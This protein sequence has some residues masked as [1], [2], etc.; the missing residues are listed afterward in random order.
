M[1]DVT[2]ALDLVSKYQDP[3]SPKMK[4][5]DWRPLRDVQEELGGIPSIPGHVEDFGAFM[6]E[7]ARKAAGPGLSPRDLIKAYAITRSS[8]QRRAQDAERLR[9]AGLDLPAG[10]SGQIRPEGAMAEWLKSPTGQ[11]Y[12]DAAEVGKVDQDAVAHAQSVMKPFGLNAESQALPWA[13]QNLSDKHGDVSSMVKRAISGDSPVAEWRE[14]GKKL[15]GIGTAKAGFVASMLGRGDQPTLDARQVILQ[16]GMPTSEAKKPMAKAGF[17]AV[18]RLAARQTALNPSMDPGL[19]PF[20]QHLT[21]HTIWDKAGNEQTT[22]SDVI[23]AMRHANAGGRVGKAGGGAKSQN[24]IIAHAIA[25]LGV[26]GHGLDQLVE[27]SLVELMRSGSTQDFMRRALEVAEKGGSY[28][29]TGAGLMQKNQELVNN[30]PR[31]S[32]IKNT[33]KSGHLITPLSEMEAEYAPKKNLEPWK[34][35]D[36]EKANRE[37][38]TLVPLVGDNTPANAVLRSVMGVPAGDVNQQGGGDYIRSEFARGDNPTGWRNRTGAANTAM[39]R[40][41]E[42]GKEGPVVGLHMAMGL[43]SADSS[44]MLLHSVVNQINHLPIKKSDIDKFD[45]EMKEKFPDTKEF[46]MPWPGIKDTQG[47]HDFFYNTGNPKRPY[48]P[49]THVSKFVQNMDSVRWRAA[50]FPDVGAARFANADPRLLGMPQLSSG[51]SATELDPAGKL[52]MNK[53]DM[54]HGTYEAGLPHKGYAG[55]FRAPVQAEDIWTTARSEMPEKIGGKP[56]DYQTPGGKTL[57]QQKLMTAM[58]G[59]KMNNQIADT[60]QKAAESGATFGNYKTG[61]AVQPT[62]AQKE[63]GNYRKEHISFQGLPISIETRKGQT[64]SGTGPNGHKWSVKLPYD[65]GYIKRTEGADGDHVDVCIGPNHQSD[66]VFIVDQHHHQTGKFD[67]HKVML[68]YRTKG[69]AERAYK[70]GFSDGKGGDRMK[71]VVEMPMSKFKAWLKNGNTKKPAKN[72]ERA[73]SLTSLYSLGHDRDAG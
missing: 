54:A 45:E 16:T 17:D 44:H 24:D 22:H 3:D 9:A 19:E 71:S 52:V 69:E 46:P 53:E 63:A 32:G 35:F 5:F 8:I 27:P 37:G 12:L 61:G 60:I 30:M 66:R 68:G 39:N 21:H 10:A 20:R 58:P 2:R 50:G 73:L 55:G 70:A 33:P 38:A 49:G 67:E 26:S 36:V 59:Q 64:R 18:D 13:A 42:Y 57:F 6:D 25:G 15:H 29:R 14:F 1:A 47:V 72:I 11:R 7:M 51:Y 56:V 28:K 31:L 34:Q 41:R 40:I 43:G 23:D 48:R 62:D 4:G 65:Y